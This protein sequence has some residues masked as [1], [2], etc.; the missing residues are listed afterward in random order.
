MCAREEALTTLERQSFSISDNLTSNF[1]TQSYVVRIGRP[2]DEELKYPISSI[3]DHE[4]G[5]IFTT[6]IKEAHVFDTF[7][8]ADKE[9]WMY[10]FGRAVPKP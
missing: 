10:T 8:A 3:D 5:G 4:D 1:T 9:A 2:G 6:D 7:D